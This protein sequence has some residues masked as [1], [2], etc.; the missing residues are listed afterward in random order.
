MMKKL[1]KLT[2]LFILMLFSAGLLTSCG[3][4]E[5][6][7]DASLELSLSSNSV[8]VGESIS[9]QLFSSFEGDVTDAASFFVNGVEISGNSYVPGE[10]NSSNEV[11]GIYDGKQSAVKTFASIEQVPSEYTR[12]VLLEDY[13][14]TWCGYCPRMVSI[15]N[16]L[17]E[18]NDRI[19]PIAIHCQGAPSDPWT[20]EF[21]ADMASPQNYNAMGAPKGKYNRIH[22]LNQYEGTHPCPNDPTIYYSQA[23]EFLN[24]SAN[25]GLAI[26]SN[27]NGNNLKMTVKVGFATDSVPDARLVVT[28]IEDGLTYN[29]VNY[30]AGSGLNCDSNYNYSS[31]PNPI[32]NF[33]QEHVLLKAYTDIY[34]DVIPQSEIS[35]GNVYSR[36]FNVQLPSNVG[37]P[38]NLKIV[39][40]VLG[41]GNSI[42]T[43]GVLNAQ[44][45]DVGSSQDFD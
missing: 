42:P 3:T 35:N 10:A 39:A 41:N 26:S 20:Y 16:Y 36:D 30:Y 22:S 45:A 44:R 4:E 19:I 29:Q 13:T 12:K 33:A 25:L 1:N 27:L 14:G 11:Y 34:G 31:M 40:F 2:H 7:G 8:N 37:N 6:V 18:Y 9:F 24:E 21:W 15:V 17:T 28:L 32:P 23:D 5:E 38:A 43:R